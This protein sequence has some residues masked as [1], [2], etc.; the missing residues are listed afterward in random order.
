MARETRAMEG[1]SIYQ[2]KTGPPGV[3]VTPWVAVLNHQALADRGRI[4]TCG[5]FKQCMNV[6][7]NFQHPPLLRMA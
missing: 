4:A 6:N 2:V 1:G 3:T 7:L 5:N